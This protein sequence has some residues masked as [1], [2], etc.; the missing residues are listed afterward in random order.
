[1]TA[2]PIKESLAESTRPSVVA[3]PGS[4]DLATPRPN[5]EPAYM[6]ESERKSHGVAANVERYAFYL[7][8]SVASLVG[9]VAAWFYFQA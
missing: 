1:M 2:T 5:I 9:A 8:V 7:F 3:S 4:I 6:K